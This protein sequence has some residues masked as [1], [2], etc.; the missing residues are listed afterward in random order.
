[1]KECNAILLPSPVYFLISFKIFFFKGIQKKKK[2]GI[3]AQ[4]KTL[5]S[6]FI[7]FYFQTALLR[8]NQ[9]AN[10]IINNPKENFSK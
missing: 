1:M 2:M 4:G 3:E 9:Q 6:N 7:T 5:S 10:K 8:T